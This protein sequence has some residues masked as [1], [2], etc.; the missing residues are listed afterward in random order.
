VLQIAS[1]LY[2]KARARV[3]HS[4]GREPARFPCL[5][6]VP[7]F[8]RDEASHLLAVKCYAARSVPHNITTIPRD[9][10]FEPNPVFDYISTLPPPSQVRLV[11]SEAQL[12]DLG[13]GVERMLL[14]VE[15]LL[16][17]ADAARAGRY[18]WGSA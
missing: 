14:V 10:S 6:C 2:N 7:G 4:I 3:E 8:V 15:D 12:K 16:N 9:Q 13:G 17:R 1:K 18:A 11:P 5:R